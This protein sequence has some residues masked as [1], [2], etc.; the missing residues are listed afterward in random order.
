MKYKTRLIVLL[1]LCPLLTMAD[2][3]FSIKGKVS[4]IISG[5]VS[6]TTVFRVPNSDT[7]NSILPD[8]VRIHDGEFVFT[9]KMEHPAM[10]SLKISTR[11]ITVFLENTTY[12]ISGALNTLTGASLQGGPLNDQWQRFASLG[13]NDMAYIKANPDTVL[14]AYLALREAIDSHEKGVA[15]YG[16]LGPDARQTWMGQEA[17]KVLGEYKKSAPGASFP[18]LALHAPDGLP[19]S[20]QQMAGKIVV[21]DFW[22]SWCAPCRA[23]IPTIR[24]HYNKYKDK[25]VE[26]ISVSVD[27]DAGKWKEAMAAEKMEW[28]QVLAAGGFE[29]E[30]GVKQLLDINHIPYV[31]VLGKDGKIAASLDFFSKDQLDTKLD[32]LISQP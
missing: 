5:Y 7:S 30:N 19:F 29:G 25:G 10:V 9:G 6:I 31:I 21:L 2:G 1:L 16:L 23:Y 12:T 3:G 15:A 4:G 26:F 32:V 11:E 13:Q 8:R 14:S 22:A 27:E 20:M 28:A 24:E 18:N 17:V